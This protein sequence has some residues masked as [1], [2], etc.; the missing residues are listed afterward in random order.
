MQIGQPVSLTLEVSLLF[1][2]L[3]YNKCPSPLTECPYPTTEAWQLPDPHPL[4]LSP[5]PK[6]SIFLMVRFCQRCLRAFLQEGRFLPPSPYAPRA[7]MQPTS[8][9]ALALRRPGHQGGGSTLVSALHLECSGCWPTAATE[10]TWRRLLFSHPS[11]PLC[12]I[13]CPARIL[14]CPEWG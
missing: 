4:L 3:A 14:P 11:L 1:S 6:L 13:V 2:T 10:G 7:A 5:S 12:L 9:H 8:L